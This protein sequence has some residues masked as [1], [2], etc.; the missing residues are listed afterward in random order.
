M[1]QQNKM[2]KRGINK[3]NHEGTGDGTGTDRSKQG[4]RFGGGLVKQAP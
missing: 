2:E 1:R 4:G 3:I